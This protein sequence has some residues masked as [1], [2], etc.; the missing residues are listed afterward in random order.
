MLRCRQCDG[1]ARLPRLIGVS[2]FR[3]ITTTAGN[4]G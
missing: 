2:R 1:R 4:L 3:P